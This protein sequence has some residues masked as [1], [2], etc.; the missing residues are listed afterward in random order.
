MFSSKNP[1]FSFPPSLLFSSLLFS[2][3]SPLLFSS[4]IFS[5]HFLI[6]YFV[7]FSFCLL[8][9]FC[10]L[11]IF[12]LFVLFILLRTLPRPQA[13]RLKVQLETTQYNTVME[14]KGGREKKR[15]GGKETYLNIRRRRREKERKIRRKG[16]F[17]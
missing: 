6:L 2:S 16:N 11:K 7:F 13:I 17:T 10:H 1:L 12:V 9:P 15:E 8:S 4:L 3:L 14:K 5:S